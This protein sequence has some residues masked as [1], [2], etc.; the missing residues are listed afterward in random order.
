MS[1][2]TRS[3]KLDGYGPDAKAAL[4]GAQSLADERSHAE[5]ETLHLLFRLLD[6]DPLV[7]KAFELSGVD[8]GDL[9]F[10]VEAVLRKI[11]QV[12]G[13]VAFLSPRLLGLTARA[14]SEASRD[15]SPVRVRHLLIAIVNEVTGLAGAVLR[16]LDVDEAKVRAALRLPDSMASTEGV[17]G[18]SVPTPGGGGG[19]GGG[20]TGD[21][22][23]RYTRDLIAEASKDRFD[24]IVGRD[25]ELRR[26]LQVIARRQKNSPVL[27]GEAG[28]G[29]R[30]I[31]YHH[32]GPSRRP[33]RPTLRSRLFAMLVVE[34]PTEEQAIG[35]CRGI[36]ERYELHH[37]VRINDPAVVA[38]VKLGKRYL[39]GRRAAR[40]GHRPDRRGR[41]AV[42]PGARRGPARARLAL[43]AAERPRGPAPVAGRRGGRSPV[44]VRK[45]VEAELAETRPAG[46]AA[47]A[48][49]VARTIAA[50]RAAKAKILDAAG[51]S[52]TRRPA[53]GDRR[54]PPRLATNDLAAE[55]V[56]CAE[57]ALRRGEPLPLSVDEHGIAG[58]V[59]QWTGGPGEWGDARERDWE[60]AVYGVP[61]P[62]PGGRP[63]RR[64]AAHRQGRAPGEAVVRSG[65][66]H[67]GAS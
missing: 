1:N 22:L 16:A 21:V 57:V 48:G 8:P 35:M 42:P 6:R 60:A 15:A 38:A 26:L 49:P 59:E 45:K 32:P 13:A 44:E 51:V 33:S 55:K 62:S 47:P 56:L 39:G 12:P 3:W 61:H 29:K 31:V 34:A 52:A 2:T 54:R 58:A 24:P 10:E 7:Q 9:M 5:V 17:V 65:A 23:A 53:Q 19:S 40:L 64:G 14:E 11:P 25:V 28:V 46:R 36:V 37:G 66:P 63:G 18:P 27:V 67:R 50:M 30:A 20:A 4:A 43:P 41:R